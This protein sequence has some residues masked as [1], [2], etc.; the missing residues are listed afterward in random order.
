MLID[1]RAQATGIRQRGE[2]ATLLMVHQ[3]LARH[4]EVHPARRRR[5]CRA[6]SL[7][8]DTNLPDHPKQDDFAIGATYQVTGR[9]FLVFLLRATGAGR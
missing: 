3:R 8:A 7:L 4:G 1:G 9:S 2:D 6:G 5:G